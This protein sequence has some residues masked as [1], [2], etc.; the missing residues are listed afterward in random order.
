MKFYFAV[1]VVITMLLGSACKN[2]SHQKG[3]PTKE[4]QVGAADDFV[5]EPGKRAGAITAN[6]TLTDL[7]AIYGSDKVVL[8]NIYLGEGQE[9]EGAVIFPDTPN[10]V[11]IGWDVPANTGHPAFVRI[12]GKGGNWKMTNGLHIGSTLAEVEKVNG[13]PFQL[14]GLWWDY[15]GAVSDW[16]GGNLKPNVNITF[17]TQRTELPEGVQGDIIL[18]SDDPNV[19]SLGLQIETI[20]LTFD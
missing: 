15:G 12:G 5:I 3:D 17:G 20:V 18:N 7:Q 4:G 2:A 9:Q 13:R 16:K 6:V 8:R 10:E 1:P 11:E 14:Y 19:Q